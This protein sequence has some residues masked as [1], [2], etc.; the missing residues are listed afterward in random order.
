MSYNADRIRRLIHETATGGDDDLIA[1]F[2]RL[3]DSIESYT[4]TVI[5]FVEAVDQSF[6]LQEQLTAELRDD[7]HAVVNRVENLAQAAALRSDLDDLR[8]EVLDRTATPED[9]R[10]A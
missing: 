2:T 5:R 6:V 7:L 8:L 10:A 9:D 4:A 1:S 3:A